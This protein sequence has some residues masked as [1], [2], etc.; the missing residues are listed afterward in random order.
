MFGDGSGGG[1]G[2]GDGGWWWWRREKGSFCFECQWESEEGERR[3]KDEA[4]CGWRW[5]KGGWLRL[6]W[7]SG[8][9]F[10]QVRIYIWCFSWHFGIFNVVVA[11]VV[12][13]VMERHA[14][15]LR[16]S[17]CCRTP[18]RD[19]RGRELTV[20]APSI[21]RSAVRQETGAGCEG[22]RGGAACERGE[23]GNCVEL[24]AQTTPIVSPP[25]V[26]EGEIVL[27]ENAS[28]P[29]VARSLARLCA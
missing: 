9:R 27:K 26:S 15:V 20:H 25:P 8:V 22:C 10:F 11:L 6:A 17:F 21:C 3:R 5:C 23:N 28:S 12:V 19:C 4:R 14:P 24:C 29:V 1:G 7:R 13:V 16:W 18:D 2:G